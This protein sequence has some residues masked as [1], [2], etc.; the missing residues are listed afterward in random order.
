MNMQYAEKEQEHKSPQ[1][2]QTH[3]KTCLNFWCYFFV[4][5]FPKKKIKKKSLFLVHHLQPKAVNEFAISAS[6]FSGTR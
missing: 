2:G 4:F 6:L 5:V 1:E 3:L